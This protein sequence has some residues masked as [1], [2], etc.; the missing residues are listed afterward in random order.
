MKNYPAIFDRV[1]FLKKLITFRVF[2]LR[3]KGEITANN[4]RAEEAIQRGV[5]QQNSILNIPIA[6]IYRNS[7][8]SQ[9][10]VLKYIHIGTWK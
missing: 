9:C 5:I 10:I 8:S 3:L 1:V 4:T 6:L 7:T 2:K